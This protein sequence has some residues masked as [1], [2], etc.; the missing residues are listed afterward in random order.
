MCGKIKT[1]DQSLEVLIQSNQVWQYQV[2]IIHPGSISPANGSAYRNASVHV[3]IFR[4]VL[5]VSIA[6]SQLRSADILWM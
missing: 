5:P 3:G 6:L 1:Q 4:R 2:F